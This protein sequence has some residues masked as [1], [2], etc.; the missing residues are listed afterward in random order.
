MSVAKFLFHYGFS[1]IDISTKLILF[2]GL[3]F[4]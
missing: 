3:R 4:I 1:I 2:H